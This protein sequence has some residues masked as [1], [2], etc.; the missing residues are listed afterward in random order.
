[1][2]V[3]GHAIAG[4]TL[5]A[6]MDPPRAGT[7]SSPLGRWA[8]LLVALAY[9]PDIAAQ[10]GVMVGVRSFTIV[11][12]SLVFALAVSAVLAL[13]LARLLRTGAATSF[14]LLLGSLLLH[15]AMDILQSPGRMPLWPIRL[16]VD[17]GVWIP[18]RLPGEILVSLPFLLLALALRWRELRPRTS[19]RRDWMALAAALLIV[20]LAAGVNQTRSQRQQ[21]LRRARQFA[22]SGQ[23]RAA[24]D[25]CERAER[26]PSTAQPGR[27]DYIRAVA[28]LGLGDR[29][30]AEQLYLRSYDA[31]SSYIWTVADLALLYAESTA[32][33]EERQAKARHWLTILRADFPRHRA[34]PRLIARVERRL[35]VPPQ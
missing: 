3:V 14:L 19:L 9:L 23:Y 2:P 17:V 5:A 11:S 27:I 20:V 26:W 34:L 4:L 25:A 24:L 7:W 28:W 1:M 22:E 18:S 21:D 29:A 33:L 6:V 15:D 10:G 31:E 8:L 12:H 13:P 35:D 16:R 32:P 30:R